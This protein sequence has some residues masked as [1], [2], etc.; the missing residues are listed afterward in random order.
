MNV[1]YA[2]VD[3]NYDCVWFKRLYVSLIDHTR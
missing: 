3:K 1:E 2:N